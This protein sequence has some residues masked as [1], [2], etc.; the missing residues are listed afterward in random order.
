MIKVCD[1]QLAFYQ[2][3]YKRYKI[4]APNIFVKYNEMDII[5]IRSSGYIDEIEIKLTKSD[6]KADFNKKIGNRWNGNTNKHKALKEGSN[7][8]ICNYF[9]FLIPKGL[10]DIDLI[11]EYCGV[12]IYNDNGKRKFVYEVRKANIIHKKKQDVKLHREIGIKMMYRYWNLLNK[13]KK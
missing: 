3:F 11:P 1:I 4:I 10:V 7:L 5:A 13:L 8:L 6:F 12:Y 2:S 9:S